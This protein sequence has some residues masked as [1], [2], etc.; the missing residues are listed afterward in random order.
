MLA[1][2]WVSGLCLG[3]GTATP[4]AGILVTQQPCGT[5]LS[6]R[7]RLVPGPAAT[8]SLADSGSGLCVDVSGQSAEDGTP[9][10][11]WPC[12][13]VGNQLFE[14]RRITGS[15]GRTQ[16]VAAHSGKCLDVYGRSV[17]PGGEVQQFG[18]HP[19]ADERQLRNQSFSL[20]S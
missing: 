8:V 7:F 3:V 15:G 14:Q 19:D 11:L 4:R 9:V 16:L 13:G 2:A 5:A 12:T 10:L 18:C 6:R 20:I 1:A 17:V